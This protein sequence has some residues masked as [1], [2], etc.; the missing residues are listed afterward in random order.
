MLRCPEDH[1]CE[2]FW[3]ACR[4]IYFY[5]HYY[6]FF[7]AALGL[8]DFFLCLSQITPLLCCTDGMIL[9]YCTAVVLEEEC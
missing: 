3:K 1:Y 9:I 8:A 7:K 2:L 6:F 4:C 5:Y